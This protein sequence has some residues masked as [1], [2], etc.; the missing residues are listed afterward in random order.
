MTS[1]IIKR[2]VLIP[3]AVVAAVLLAGC[4]LDPENA[5][6]QS[7][8][9]AAAPA[10]S[11]T[12]QY[13]QPLPSQQSGPA[14]VLVFPFV[15]AGNPGTYDWI[16][17]GVQQSLLAD[18]SSSNVTKVVFPAT[19]PAQGPV[20]PIAVGEQSGANFVII[21]TFQVN[22][23]QVRVTGQVFD[24]ASGQNLGGLKATGAIADLFKLEDSLNDQVMHLLPGSGVNAAA[25]QPAPVAQAPTT[26]VQADAP[27]PAAPSVTYVYSSSYPYAYYYG[28]YPYAGWPVYGFVG[29][30]SYYPRGYYHYP[31]YRPIYVYPARPGVVW[32]GGGARLGGGFRGGSGGG[33]R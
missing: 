33:R 6:A 12:P 11:Q 18:L 26:Y 20:D 22:D 17:R 8:T 7:A 16:G 3:V 32:G 13:A 2:L 5:P 10:Y 27:A 31:A 1:P 21:G 19:Q 24:V 28:G 23:T 25:A 4:V 29:G 14:S 9:P 15:P 30:Y